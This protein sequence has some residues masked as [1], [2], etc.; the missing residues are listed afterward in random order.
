M[1]ENNI[2]SGIYRPFLAQ[3]PQ[4]R[5]TIKKSVKG[6]ININN[7]IDSFSGWAKACELDFKV[8]EINTIKKHIFAPDLMELVYQVSGEKLNIEKFNN[9]IFDSLRKLCQIENISF[10]YKE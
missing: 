8:L 4:N 3:N 6:P 7:F 2:S 5:I 9:F 1:E 10:D